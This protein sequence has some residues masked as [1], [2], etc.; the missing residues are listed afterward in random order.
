MSWIKVYC[1]KPGAVFRHKVACAHG[2]NLLCVFKP[3]AVVS[4]TAQW[5]TGKKEG[6]QGWRCNKHI[7]RDQPIQCSNTDAAMPT[8]HVLHPSWVGGVTEGK[9]MFLPL[10][11]GCIG[12][13]RLDRIGPLRAQFYATFPCLCSCN[14]SS[15]SGNKWIHPHCGMQCTPHGHGY[16]SAGR[17]V[18]IGPQSFMWLTPKCTWLLCVGEWKST[19]TC[20]DLWEWPGP[21]GSFGRSKAPSFSPRLL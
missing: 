16:I 6:K 4:G 12:A 21:G 13:E 2:R 20:S 7:F 10:P 14:A 19:R 8:V 5:F 1:Y 17:L 18:R 9:E 15:R 3:C 11:W